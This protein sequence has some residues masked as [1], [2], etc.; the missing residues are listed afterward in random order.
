MKIRKQ[1][2]RK[3]MLISLLFLA[4]QVLHLS[5]PNNMR[6]HLPTIAIIGR[7]NVGK[8]TLFNRLAEENKALVSR[9][10]GTTRDRREADCLWRGRIIRIVDTA[11]L[12]VP[13]AEDLEQDAMKQT[14]RAIEQ[15]DLILFVL[16]LKG[17]PLPQE[18][19]IA[20]RLRRSKKP[21]I[22]VG[23][24]A[25]S[26]AQILAAESGEWRLGGLPTPIPISALRGTGLGDMLDR[27]YESLEKHG[28]PPAELS[29]ISPV[30]VAVIGKPNVG[31]SSVLNQLLK[32]ER[33]I[34]SPIAHTTREPVDTLVEVGEKNYLF[35]DTAGMRKRGK[36][37][38]TGG[39]EAIGVERTV[40]TI[41]RADIALLVLDAS[42][43]FGVQ[44]RILAGLLQETGIG[45][46]VVANKWDLIPDKTPTT[47]GKFSEAIKNALPFLTWAPV[48]FTSAKTGQRVDEL[49]HL[50]D[51]VQTARFTEIPLEELEAFFIKATRARLP[52]KG[53]GPKPPKVLGIKQVGVAPPTFAVTIR[54]KRTDV[55]HPS[56]LRYLENRLH[57][58]FPLSGTPIKVSARL[59]TV[60]A[61]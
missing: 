14:E 56:Y 33:F 35:I 2:P 38:K 48:L 23:N 24:K 26:P 20:E 55:I 40:E 10:P 9:V 13:H 4:K 41:K 52:M 47:I 45:V 22:T 44:D 12:D 51:E 7:T 58:S 50:I 19:K 37:R 21:V 34:V 30:R 54:A 42:E 57:E 27:V 39:L 60:R 46:I 8:S 61:V 32:E 5:A 53:K 49:F 36:V 25:E 29:Q 16:D 59:P 18:R 28:I 3:K 11:G 15:A 17:V 43:P 1:K 31:K 6:P